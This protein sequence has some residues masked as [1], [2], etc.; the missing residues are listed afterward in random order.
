MIGGSPVRELARSRI[1]TPAETHWVGEIFPFTHRVTVAHRVYGAV[2]TD[3]DWA[4]D[5]L[6]FE[7]WSAPVHTQ[8]G[9]D[10]IVISEKGDAL[11]DFGTEGGVAPSEELDSEY[12]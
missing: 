10:D 12:E 5:D 8:E 1:E 11:A 3:F 9:S 6:I 2:T 4:P 7:E